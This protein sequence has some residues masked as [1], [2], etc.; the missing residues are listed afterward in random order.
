M[1]DM[2]DLRYV[3]KLI[4]ML[5][6]SSRR[7]RRDLL[8]QG[9]EAPHLEEPAAARGDADRPVAMPA[10]MPAAPVVSP[11]RLDRASMPSDW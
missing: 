1:A 2:I 7:F 3:K 4:E 6:G 9:D 10:L 5:D 8:R 11:A